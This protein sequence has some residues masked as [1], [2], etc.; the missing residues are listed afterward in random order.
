M[1]AAPHV[2]D[3]PIVLSHIMPT[4]IRLIFGGLGVAGTVLLLVELGPALWPPSFLTL[5]FGFI[6]VGG[7]SVTL[8]FVAGAALGPD[9]M[10]EIRPGQLTVTYT[11]FNKTSVK[12]YRLADF[13]SCDVA[14]SHYDSDEQT[15]QLVCR[16][17]L[18]K[19]VQ[20]GLESTPLLMAILAFLRDPLATSRTNYLAETRLRS[21]NFSKREQAEKALA[22]LMGR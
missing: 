5:F 3:E 9:Q 14:E 7:L 17:P 21:P 8:A 1:E 15:Y 16:L 10:W 13:E 12:T 20:T 2:P 22:H 11:L 6:V 18:G 19:T 4:P